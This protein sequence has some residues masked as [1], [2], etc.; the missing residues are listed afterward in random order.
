ME[1]SIRDIF[2]FWKLSW[3]LENDNALFKTR[4]CLY[5]K[6]WKNNTLFKNWWLGTMCQILTVTHKYIYI[7]ITYPNSPYLSISRLLLYTSIIFHACP[8]TSGKLYPVAILPRPQ[9]AVVCPCPG[10]HVFCN[11]CLAASKALCC[12]LCRQLGWGSSQ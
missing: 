4:T 12:P 2:I 3:G 7:Y 6:T 5:T 8:T 10:A 1:S 9:D 11:D